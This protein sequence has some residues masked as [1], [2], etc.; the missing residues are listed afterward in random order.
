MFPKV[1][2]VLALNELLGK[3]I[4]ESVDLY[5][6]NLREVAEI[7]TYLSQRV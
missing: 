5:R 3:D 7:N 2:F 4:Q 6:L 1:R